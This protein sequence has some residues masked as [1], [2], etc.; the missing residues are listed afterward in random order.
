MEIF[1]DENG[2]SNLKIVFKNGKMYSESVDL[3][4]KYEDLLIFRIYGDKFII[5]PWSTI[6]SIEII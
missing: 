5:F 1:K 3:I 2:W 4:E 6:E